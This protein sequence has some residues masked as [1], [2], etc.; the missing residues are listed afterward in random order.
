MKHHTL[1]SSKDKGKQLK[2][3]L[4]K[5]FGAFR[6]NKVLIIETGKVY[7][8]NQKT[9]PTKKCKVKNIILLR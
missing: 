3:R 5:C 9:I 8:T 2:C 1:F 4:L 7:Q 6:V